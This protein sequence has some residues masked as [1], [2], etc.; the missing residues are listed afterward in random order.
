MYD[1]EVRLTIKDGSKVVLLI[2]Y[3]RI[4]FE[5][6]QVKETPIITDCTKK[7]CEFEYF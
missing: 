7:M 3:F 5:Y 4:F 1:N 2:Y 6:F